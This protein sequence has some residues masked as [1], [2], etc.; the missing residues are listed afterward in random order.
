MSHT[1]LT[2]VRFAV[3]ALVVGCLL[4][5][6]SAAP[7]DDRVDGSRVASVQSPTTGA[8]GRADV[9]DRRP[10][11]PLDATNDEIEA[12]RAAWGRCVAKEG[13]PGYEDGRS[14]IW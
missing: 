2:M 7:T 9:E 8:T 12:L 1:F 5:G 13:G 11:I 3:P 10:L 14:V 6:C 4:A